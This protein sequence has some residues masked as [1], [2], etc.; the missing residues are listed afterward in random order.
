MSKIGDLY[1]RAFRTGNFSY[2]AAN[3]DKMES[4]LD[5]SLPVTN[6]K[7][8]LSKAA[9]FALVGGL[10]LTGVL[11][12]TSSENEI[13]IY[14]NIIAEKVNPN[15]QE[16]KSIV[17]EMEPERR[18]NQKVQKMAVVKDNIN[19]KNDNQKPEKTDNSTQKKLLPKNLVTSS[20]R[21][22]GDESILQIVKKENQ[23]STSIS[24]IPESSLLAEQTGNILAS[25]SLETV[26]GDSSEIL[27]NIEISDKKSELRT[28]TSLAFLDPRKLQT[29][30][31]SMELIAFDYKKYKSRIK[32][33]MAPKLF[34][35]LGVVSEKLD[36]DEDL[37]INVSEE[38]KNVALTEGGNNV[39]EAGINAG[40][41]WKGLV[42]YS[43]LMIR[44]QRAE[45]NINYSHTTNWEEENIETETN[46]SEVNKTFLG[47]EI[48]TVIRDGKKY[49]ERTPIYQIDSVYETNSDT[50]FTTHSNT[51]GL[52]EKFTYKINYV[53]IPLNVGYEYQINRFFV[54]VNVG[55]NMSVL[56]SVS[57][58][59]YNS[60]TNSVVAFNDKSDLNPIV[61]I[62]NAAVG[63]GYNMSPQLSL[64]VQPRFT[65]SLNSSFKETS[66]FATT[67]HGT[68]ANFM[69]QYNF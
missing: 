30:S 15:L 35:G 31:H 22:P 17:N 10:T 18:S 47:D 68:G 5:E 55:M 33:K 12:N 51:Q 59:V 29:Q 49:F 46:L 8:W 50:G 16:K 40:M 24:S 4:L 23:F 63:I 1:K 28:F 45:Y 54:S 61:Y 56:S 13:P 43:G 67:Y 58:N 3:W 53:T 69:L 44:Q 64:T 34:V 38:I 39:Y 21:D 11:F 27:N 19:S 25:T 52:D 36:N 7:S 37:N 9:T 20:N 60:E 62:A 65:K 57:G 6:S 26:G 42:I 2:N 14:K 66:D 32:L 48:K 41:K